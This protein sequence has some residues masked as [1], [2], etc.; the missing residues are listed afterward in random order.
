MPLS[1]QAFPGIGSAEPPAGF[2]WY[3][4]VLTTYGN[5]LP[6][7]PR[8]F[9][10]RH[11]RQHVDGDY[12]SPPGEDYSGL[13]AKSSLQMNH[14]P[15]QIDVDYRSVLGLALIE[16]LRRLG[17]FVLTAAV[18][19][20]HVHLLVKI[21]RAQARHWV[22]LAKKHAW[23]EMRDAGWNKKLW[24]KRGKADRVDSK[25]HH[26]NCFAYIVN[27]LRQGAWVWVWEGVDDAVVKRIVDS[28]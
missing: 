28:R 3:H 22:G 23:F 4:I 1:R 25:S 20:N 6:G 16:H 26:K 2:G 5:W 17:G 21:P 27:H 10:T 9:R 7:D 15:A 18:T 19:G 8:G 24:A 14:A 12:K 13:Y 11:H